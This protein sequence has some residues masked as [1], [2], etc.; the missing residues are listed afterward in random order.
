[1]V[2]IPVEKFN[3]GKF[4]DDDVINAWKWFT[5][6]MSE[7]DWKNRKA[8]IEEQVTVTFKEINPQKSRQGKDN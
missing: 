7:Q 5:S 1:M 2:R 6:F 8:R 4:E 3:M